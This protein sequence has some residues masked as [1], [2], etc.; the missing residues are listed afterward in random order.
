M[1]NT[2][3]KQPKR[4]KKLI[5]NWIVGVLFVL[6]V[7]VLLLIVRKNVISYQNEQ[8]LEKVIE[9]IKQE[10]QAEE[11]RY[12]GYKVV[13]TIRIP[14]IQLEYP[15]LEKTTQESM[16]YAV[17]KFWGTE[18]TD[19]GNYTIAGHNNHNGT[20][21]GKVKT[22]QNGD[23]IQLT[24]TKGNRVIYQVV[25][26]YSTG[27]N[28]VTCVESIHS[29]KRELTLITCTNGNKQRLITRAEEK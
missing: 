7:V 23:E 18:I 4:K 19:I 16:K 10:K 26:Q 9:Q 1:E 15:I 27:P 28:D 3:N 6:F 5:Y 29:G 24:D 22:L 25:N 12:K 20:M 11:I 21:F 2:G 14:K 17:T 13:G 8:E